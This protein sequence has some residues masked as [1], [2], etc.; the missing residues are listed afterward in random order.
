MPDLRDLFSR[1]VGETPGLDAISLRRVVARRRRRRW[2]VVGA[3]V[4]A[5][6]VAGG[7]VVTA[8]RH[9]NHQLVIA[10]SGETTTSSGPAPTAPATTPAPGTLG[11]PSVATHPDAFRGY[12]KLAYES[13]GA[14]WILDGT[15]AAP[16]SVALPGTLEQA[17]WSPDG[18]WLAIQTGSG[19]YAANGQGD[20]FVM[21]ADGTNLARVP[22][23]AAGWAWSPT[24]DVLAVVN[25]LP[26]ARNG[27]IAVYAAPDFTTPMTKP[28]PAAEPAGFIAW[29]PDGDRLIFKTYTPHAPFVDHLWSLDE[30]NCPPVCDAAPRA[31]R[32]SVHLPAHNDLGFDFAGWSADGTRLLVWFD[33]AHSASIAFDGLTVASIPLAGGGQAQL[34]VMLAKPS[35]IADVVGTDQAIVAVGNDRTWDS[36]RQLDTCNLATG[37]CTPLVNQ[38]G[39]TIDPAVSPDGQ[40]LA[41]VATDPVVFANNAEIPPKSSIQWTRSRRLVVAGIKNQDPHVI[42]TDG[43]V[44]PRW[45]TDSHHLLFWRA[46]YL[47]LIDINHPAP[48]AIAGQL[49]PRPD[50]FDFGPFPDY[51][52]IF[53][54]NDVW[55][56]VAWLAPKT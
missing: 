31:I 43:V 37:T 55:D 6:V 47:W 56:S 9:A 26:A 35:W 1:A 44:A 54:G 3:F 50:T 52:Y 49:E 48:I 40:H 32:V 15:G 28:I 29:S 10:P 53:P 34:P 42:A 2:V 41:Y 18:A 20:V 21:P 45:T 17:S 36:H 19:P 51:A 11:Y 39:P 5:A 46:G 13:D 8:V 24:R 30:T 25:Q 27:S 22:V 12:G 16:R 7:A 14:L 23:A 38:P 4:I 33:V